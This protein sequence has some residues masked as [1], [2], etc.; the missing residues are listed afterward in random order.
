MFHDRNR[1]GRGLR[2]VLAALAFGALVGG[3][4]RGE[5]GF[6]RWRPHPARDPHS[7]ASQPGASLKQPPGARDCANTPVR[8]AVHWEPRRHSRRESWCALR[9]IIQP[10]ADELVFLIG[11]PP[12]SEFSGYV[13]NQTVGGQAAD[14]T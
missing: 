8:Y 14:G 5:R 12:M 4:G 2:F 3:S 13:T 7:R 9:P 11:R 6:S 10:Q 1:L